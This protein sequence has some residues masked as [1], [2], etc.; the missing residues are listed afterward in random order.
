MTIYIH[1]LLPAVFAEIIVASATYINIYVGRAE[2]VER[3]TFLQT[4][5][6]FSY[7]IFYSS[8]STAFTFCKETQV[9][10]SCRIS[11]SKGNIA[12]QQYSR[13]LSLLNY[14]LVEISVA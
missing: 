11:T 7:Q 2:H 14:A 5:A 10:K 8:A 4:C 12:H 6:T 13:Q 1:N 3:T 9:H